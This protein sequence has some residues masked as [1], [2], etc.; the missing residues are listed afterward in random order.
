[1]T[2][3]QR[4][5]EAK[6]QHPGVLLAVRVGDFYE[7]YG[8]DA[9]TAA[10]IL[11]ITLTGRPD[12]E[13]GRVAMAGVPYHSVEKYLARLIT[14]GF[15]VALA[16]DL[17]GPDQE[18][19]SAVISE[20][21]CYRYS[22]TRIWDKSLPTVA[23]LMLNPSTADATEDDPTIR[24]CIGFAKSWGYGGLIVVNVFAWRA[25]DPRE[26][27]TVAEPRGPAS[28]EHWTYARVGCARTVA[29]WG[30]SGPKLTWL[31]M[32]Q[33][34]KVFP[35][36]DCLGFNADG[37]PKHPLYLRSATPLYKFSR[38]GLRNPW[39]PGIGELA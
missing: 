4:Y 7:F 31:R 34:L 17:S 29:A 19:K 9:E 33:I 24:K 16:D 22:L 37:S 28:T 20:C 5:F 15:K 39:A 14:A 11:E 2:F 1:M 18:I 10:R 26:L 13:R 38:N 36:L 6:A 32:Q 12:A 35:D 8:D 21:G 25:T 27:K 30:K 3:L 23:F